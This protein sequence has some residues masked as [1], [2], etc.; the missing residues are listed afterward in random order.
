MPLPPGVSY[1]TGGSMETMADD[2]E[3]QDEPNPN[4][5]TS[6]VPPPPPGQA[7]PTPAPAAPPTAPNIIL[8]GPQGP[9]PAP[10]G[11]PVNLLTPE[12]A[13]N[14]FMWRRL[15]QQTQ[16]LPLA[17]TE[18][19]VSAA[20]RYQGQRQ[21]QQDLASGMSPGEALARSAPMIFGG[22]KQ[23]SL[24][25]AASMVRATAKPQPKFTDVGGV[26]YRHNLDG[27]V[28]AVTG[29]KAPTPPRANQFDLAEHNSILT[30]IREVQKEAANDEIGSPEQQQHASQLRVLQG[31][32]DAIRRRAGQGAPTAPP[33]TGTS[34]G[35]VRVRRPDGKIGS[36]PASQKDAALAQGYSLIQ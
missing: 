23:G 14:N 16:D 28:T 34:T 6:I 7:A 35:R 22:P 10:T 31:Q 15:A 8:R 5:P 17:Q 3:I 13:A 4:D 9:T 36:I 19:A 26:L 30:Q 18:Q 32:L 33:R 25:Q 2:P 20:L 24:G 1:S 29:P 27:T 11:P 21:Y 12:Q